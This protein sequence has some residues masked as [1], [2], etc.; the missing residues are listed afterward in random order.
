MPAE[1]NIVKALNLLTTASQNKVE[2][3]SNDSRFHTEDLREKIEQK[4]VVALGISE[5]ITKGKPTGKLAIT[6]YVKKK[7]SPKKLSGHNLIPPTLPESV[8]GK[9]A[10]PTDVVVL[11]DIIPEFNVKRKPV[12][13]GHSIAH[14]KLTAGTLGALVKDKSNNLFI[15][16]NSHVLA[17]SGKAKKGD[18][19]FYPGPFD[20][21]QVADLV[22]T[23]HKFKPFILGDD[24]FNDVDCAIAK[25]IKT[26]IVDL[27]SEI[28]GLGVPKGIIAPKRGMKITKVG[29][30]TG[31][32]VGE[33]KDV[34]F[35]FTIKYDEPGIGVI[36]FK[37]QVLCTRYTDGGDSGSLVLDRKT[38][39]AV[40]LHFAGANGGSVFAPI[41]KVLKAM[42]V[43][44]VTK[45]ILKKAVE[46]ATKKNP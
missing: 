39:K 15:L 17:R 31:K 5:K 14:A 7:I 30:T 20:G 8:S 1:K 46:K 4:N 26:R 25:P 21:G 35:R 6:F 24:F 44:L 16:S 12:Q 2:S 11:G 18:Q 33:I 36:G 37:D 19:I 43:Q 27:V 23:L 38:G 13:P 34:H 40:G 9:L 29:R 41:D 42:N 28:K 10:I 32:T 22:A 3:L 45:S